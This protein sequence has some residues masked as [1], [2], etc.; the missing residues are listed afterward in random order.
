MYNRILCLTIDLSCSGFMAGNCCARRQVL[1]KRSK[2][3]ES[4]TDGPE[5]GTSQNRSENRC[6]TDGTKDMTKIK[7]VLIACTLSKKDIISPT[8]A[9]EVRPRTKLLMLRLK[10]PQYLCNAGLIY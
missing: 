1:W 3:P 2:K 10:L 5:A 8:W 4:S 9:W 6:K 7:K